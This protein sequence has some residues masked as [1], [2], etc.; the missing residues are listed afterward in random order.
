MTIDL[1]AIKARLAAACPGPWTGM[2]VRRAIDGNCL[3]IVREHPDGEHESMKG[4]TL[5]IAA[6]LLPQ[7][8]DNDTAVMLLHSR[9][10]MDALVAEVERLRAQRAL[11]NDELA[12]AYDRGR[13]KERHAAVAWLNRQATDDFCALRVREACCWEKAATIIESGEHRREE[14]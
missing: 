6:T 4:S 5:T 8:G 11:D 12:R 3:A 13:D 1:D 14:E 10:D 9:A 2:T 7:Y